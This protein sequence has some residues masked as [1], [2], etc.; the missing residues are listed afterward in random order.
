VDKTTLV[1]PLGARRHLEPDDIDAG[2]RL[3][4]LLRAEGFPITAAL[5]RYRPEPAEWRLFIASPVVDA[6]GP[7]R[8][9]ERILQV[10]RSPEGQQLGLDLINTSVIRP[11]DPLV[12]ALR[13]A[14]PPSSAP[15]RVSQGAF[16]GIP[17]EDAVVYPFS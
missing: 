1:V 4:D 11:Q 14:L 9:Y 5:W 12:R 15:T 17:I 13:R 8:A 2:S 3:L 7:R 10:L 16:D 6:E